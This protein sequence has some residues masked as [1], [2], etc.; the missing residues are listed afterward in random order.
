MAIKQLLEGYDGLFILKGTVAEYAD[1]AKIT[2][3]INGD[4]YKTA[5]GTHYVFEGKTDTQS[6]IWALW[7]PSYTKIET[8]EA[9]Q[10]AI[11]GYLS[12]DEIAQL[13]T[14][15]TASLEV[16][17]QTLSQVEREAV[18]EE[19]ES[20]I[21]KLDNVTIEQVQ[22]IVENAL[23]AQAPSLTEEDV[24]A[25]I[26]ESTASIYAADFYKAG[27]AGTYTMTG[28]EFATF[29]LNEL[30]NHWYR[31]GGSVATVTI[32]LTSAPTNPN[33]N[34]VIRNIMGHMTL[35]I[36]T[37]FPLSANIFQISNV[38]GCFITINCNC[39]E[40]V[41]KDLQVYACD[42]LLYNGN[43]MG[44]ISKV[45]AD[46]NVCMRFVNANN[47]DLF[48]NFN[49][50]NLIL[51][52]QTNIT[53]LAL[54]G[55]LAFI[56]KD[57]QV[58]I[59]ILSPSSVDGG[60]IV[61]ERIGNTWDTFARKSTVQT[62]IQRD[63]DIYQSIYAY[64]DEKLSNATYDLQNPTVIIGDN[65]VLSLLSTAQQWISP[66]QGLVRIIYKAVLGVAPIVTK[67]GDAISGGLSLLGTGTPTDVPCVQGDV[68][69]FSGVLGILD[70]FTV[71][72][73]PSI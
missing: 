30:S 3:A 14:D 12:D 51:E 47:I 66:G 43:S 24:Q 25:I 40:V 39:E 6:G 55:S 53:N 52:G 16:N 22:Q 27:I 2:D 38:R 31:S 34:P 33:Y 18:I 49:G 5:N 62:H 73:Y 68:F 32:N 20:E 15:M 61:D 4:I 64:I 50:G 21:S 71:Y 69:E 70:S 56:N 7:M 11:A 46:H 54:G 36:N 48:V 57:A 45:T 8:D 35:I 1:L 63:S 10:A 72:Y 28:D 26:D 42:Y 41:C 67:N 59:G 60:I 37:N 17:G 13:I 44:T 29:S 58:T 23:M 65:G 9:I 19:V